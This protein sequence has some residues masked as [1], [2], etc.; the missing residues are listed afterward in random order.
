MS[1]FI[2]FLT[3]SNWCPDYSPTK[4]ALMI[5]LRFKIILITKA[6]IKDPLNA[7]ETKS[8]QTPPPAQF[9]RPVRA[10][11]PRGPIQCMFT[12]KSFNTTLED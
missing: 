11:I 8:P 9:K 12:L 7:H 5:L 2:F 6:K 4:A 1:R 3:N 10:L